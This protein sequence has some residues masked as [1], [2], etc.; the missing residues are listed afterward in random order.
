MSRPK[1]AVVV[2]LHA[3]RELKDHPERELKKLLWRLLNEKHHGDLLA[4]SEA[5]AVA[6]AGEV[7]LQLLS[8]GFVDRDELYD[9]LIAWGLQELEDIATAV[10]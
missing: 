2:C 10:A 8:K 9:A 3:Y 5:F 7:T 1:K 4:A 6:R